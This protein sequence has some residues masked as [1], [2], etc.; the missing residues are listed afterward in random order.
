MIFQWRAQWDN[1]LSHKV[2]IVGIDSQGRCYAVQV[3]VSLTIGSYVTWPSLGQLM[4]P[5]VLACSG[6]VENRGIGG[7]TIEGASQTLERLRHYSFRHN[8]DATNVRNTDG[9]PATAS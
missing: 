1:F 3:V 8:Q 9:E 5:R 4:A 6:P 2:W 7:L